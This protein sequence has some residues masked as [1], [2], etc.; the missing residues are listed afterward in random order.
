MMAKTIAYTKICVAAGGKVRSQTK[1]FGTQDGM[2]M[3]MAVRSICPDVDIT[4]VETVEMVH[5]AEGN[6]I[7]TYALVALPIGDANTLR[8]DADSRAGRTSNKERA[9]RAFKELDQ[10]V[11]PQSKVTGV[12]LLNV[13]NEDYKR[14]RDETLQKPGAVIGQMTLQGN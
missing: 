12:N 4:G 9:D 2:T 13:D 6:K 3:E 11:E 1:M 8:K 10:R 5:V 14:K 7:R